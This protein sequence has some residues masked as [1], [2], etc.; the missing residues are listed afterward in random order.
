MPD[1]NNLEN[2]SESRPRPE[3]RCPDAASGSRWEGDC[4]SP[5]EGP[6]E[7]GQRLCWRKACLR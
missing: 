5:S 6:C 3:L 1:G 7:W 4:N 2:V